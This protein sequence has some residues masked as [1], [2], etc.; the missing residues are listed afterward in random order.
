MI[1]LYFCISV[2][3]QQTLKALLCREHA[4]Q[5]CELVQRAFGLA[6]LDRYAVCSHIQHQVVREFGLPDSA[7]ELLQSARLYTVNSC[8]DSHEAASDLSH[9]YCSNIPTAAPTI[10]HIHYTHQYS[11]PAR[12]IHVAQSPPQS[13]RILASPHSHPV[14]LAA[15]TKI[16]T[17]Q[18][19]S[20]KLA[21]LPRAISQPAPGHVNGQQCYE[22]RR[23][24][25]A[26]FSPVIHSGCVHSRS[27][28]STAVRKQSQVST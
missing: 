27:A 1:T 5:H 18:Q 16:P 20:H 2:P 14:L 9:M 17:L 21:H 28:L 26:S 25:G 23:H 4:L 6:C 3:D 11:T 13:P 22:T 10:N 12:H 8:D 24:H 19:H 15:T 7:V